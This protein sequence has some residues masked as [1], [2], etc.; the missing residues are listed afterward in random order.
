MIKNKLRKQVIMLLVVLGVFVGT[1]EGIITKLQYEDLLDSS[2]A[3]LHGGRY[4]ETK[5]DIGICKLSEDVLDNST[6]H[7]INFFGTERFLGFSDV[8][9]TP[10]SELANQWLYSS[11][12]SNLSILD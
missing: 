4:K 9:N 7:D 11:H 10:V 12:K 8:V 6:F 2:S 1:T 3:V 5:L